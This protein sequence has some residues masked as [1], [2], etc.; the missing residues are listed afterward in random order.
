[1]AP[2]TI[3]GI[4]A[5]ALLCGLVAL[6]AVVLVPFAGALLWASVLVLSTRPLHLRLERAC[7][8]RRLAAAGVMTAA[9]VLLLVAPLA[10]LLLSIA[11]QTAALAQL[12]RSVLEDGPPGPPEWLAGL[13]V[14]GPAL[15][16]AWLDLAGDADRLAQTARGLV[17]PAS[18]ALLATVGAVGRGLFELTLAVLIA[19]FLWAH[20]DELSEGVAAAARRVSG[21]TEAAVAVAVATVRAVVYG[22]IGTA[23]VQGVLAAIGF[24]LAGV[25]GALLLGAVT[26]VVSVLP[27]GPPLVWLPVSAWLF[28]EHGPWWGAFMLGWGALIVSSA[29]NVVRPYLISLGSDLPLVLIILGVLGGLLAFGLTGVLVGPVVLAVA[30]N[31]LL[32]WTGMRKD[33]EGAPPAG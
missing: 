25:P 3:D 23:V 4:V 26:A 30:H 6:C 7:G 29:D 16:D 13:P 14:V 28:A 21:R 24:S 17:D 11:D 9:T 27:F 18:R 19:F 1:M 8:G 15:A 20:A 12:V 32:A 33:G 10:V 2:R 31:L 22:V 5:L